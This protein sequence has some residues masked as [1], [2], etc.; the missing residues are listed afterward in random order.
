MKL[1]VFHGCPHGTGSG[2]SSVYYIDRSN[3]DLL[4][5]INRHDIQTI[6]NLLLR[7]HLASPHQLRALNHDRVHHHRGDSNDCLLVAV[8]SGELALLRLALE[9]EVVPPIGRVAAVA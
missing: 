2:L 6:L 5:H 1:L 8:V 4:R 3:R 9:D 7:R